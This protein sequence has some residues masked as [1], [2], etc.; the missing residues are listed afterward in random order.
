MK[1]EEEYVM[2]ITASHVPRELLDSLSS[3][4][5]P[6]IFP[7]WDLLGPK[8]VPQNAEF[9]LSPCDAEVRDEKPILDTS[10]Y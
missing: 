3:S 2:S 5:H 10:C 7:L 1:D 6:F 9:R 8:C 4:L